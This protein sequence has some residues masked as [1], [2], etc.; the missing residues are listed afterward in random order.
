MKSEYLF[1]AVFA[2]IVGNFAWRYF[3]T[4]SLTG[5]ILGGTIKREVG[6]VEFAGG[7]AF[8]RSLKVHA[9]ESSE[10]GPFVALVLVSKS[11]FSASMTPFKLSKAQAQELVTLLQQA[12]A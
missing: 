8:S 2:L 9:M 3:R 7:A 12:M 4:G 11:P 5:A 1:F 10:G 6:Q